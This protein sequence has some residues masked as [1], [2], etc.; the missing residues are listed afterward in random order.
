MDALHQLEL[1]WILFLQ[2]LGGWVAAPSRLISMLGQEEF[3]MLVMPALYWSLDAGLGFRVGLMLL[4]SNGVNMIAK[5]AFHSPRPYWIDARVKGYAAESSFGLPSNHA[6]CATSIW[7]LIAA[8]DRETWLRIIL[9]VVIF[10]IGLSRIFLGVHFISDVVAGWLIGGV[11]VWIFVKVE[12]PIVDWLRSLSLAQMA[13][14]AVISTILLVVASLIPVMALGSWQL[15][16]EWQQNA[17]ADQPA[18]EVNPLDISG[19]FTIAGTWLGFL[20]GAAWLYHRQGGFDAS[21]TPRE[22]LLRYFI[23]AAGVLVLWFG[24]GQ[25]FP[26]QSDVLSY[27]LRFFR[28]TLVGLWMS[29]VAPLVFERLGIARGSRVKVASLSTQ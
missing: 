9:V 2:S 5:A 12:R 18:S 14:L 24:L 29:A 8:K 22:R 15:P 20:L 25:I 27:S 21:G 23:G 13:A 16:A 19:T 4:L 11:L 7:G 1:T 3:F 28:Y 17:L 26:R 6:Q 10:L